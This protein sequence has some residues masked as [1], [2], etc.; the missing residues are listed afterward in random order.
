MLNRWYL[1][2]YVNSESV[3]EFA[4]MSSLVLTGVNT[5]SGIISSYLM[6]IFYQKELI[7]KG[8]TSKKITKIIPYIILFYLFVFIFL[9][10]SNEIIILIIADS[11]YLSNSW[12]IPVMFIAV[13]IHSVGMISTYEI[14]A[15]GKTNK[16]IFSSIIP[17][18]VSLVGGFIFIKEFAIIGA[19]I[20]F[21]AS[22]GLYGILT[23]LVSNKYKNLKQSLKT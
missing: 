4:L 2:I 17:G 10:F 8:Y 1:N 9:L 5:F 14:Y 6:P 15:D 13:S 3:A 22:Y 16:L 11:R 21:C 20:V 7:E 18:I 19:L 23:I 12:M